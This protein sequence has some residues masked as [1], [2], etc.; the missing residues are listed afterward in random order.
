VL[1]SSSLRGCYAQLFRRVP[2]GARKVLTLLLC[3][4]IDQYCFRFKTTPMRQAE[5][6]LQGKFNPVIEVFQLL[7][8]KGRESGQNQNAASTVE[9]KLKLGI[10]STVM[11]DPL[12][13]PNLQTPFCTCNDRLTKR[14]PR[15]ILLQTQQ[16]INS[17]PLRTREL[18]SQHR[19]MLILQ[20]LRHR[21][22]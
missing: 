8:M 19:G 20:Q 22:Q 9:I 10:L 2:I 7:E 1:I 6:K 5:F 17:R 4:S 18:L 16:S 15:S 12:L 21:E 14:I 13:F 11:A 3:R